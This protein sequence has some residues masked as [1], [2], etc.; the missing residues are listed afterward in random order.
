[1]CVDDRAPFRFRP[2]DRERRIRHGGPG[3]RGQLH[4][5][6]Q[7]GQVSGPVH[8]RLH[9]SDVRGRSVHIQGLVLRVRD[10]QHRGPGGVRFR[11]R[12][13]DNRSNDG[14]AGGLRTGG[15][16]GRINLQLRGDVRYARARR[17]HNIQ[18]HVHRGSGHVPDRVPLRGGRRRDVLARGGRVHPEPRTHTREGGWG[19]LLVRVHTLGGV[20]QPH[21]RGQGL[22]L[23][24]AVP[25]DPIHVQGRVHQRDVL[26]VHGG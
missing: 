7:G 20:L 4:R 23:L 13:A 22:Q 2:V 21:L 10:R 12:G 18:V 5:L 9:A 1:M 11:S 8:Q 3:E 6:L 19:A 25:R 14:S 24:S 15:D 26:D 16:R 17:P